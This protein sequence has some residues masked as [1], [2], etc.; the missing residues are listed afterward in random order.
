MIRTFSVI[1]AAL[2]LASLAGPADAQ[3]GPPPPRDGAGM[4]GEMGSPSPEME[5]RMAEHRAQMARDMHVILRLRPDQESAWQAFEAAMGP[6]PR[7]ARPPGMADGAPSTTPQ[8]LDRMDKMMGE[9]QARHARVE[10][11][12]RTFY[13]ALSPDQQQVFD[14]L[15]RLRGPHMGRPGG[16]N[17]RGA[18]WKHRRD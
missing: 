3:M 9:M 5:K 6:P 8:R 12:T 15:E 10:S 4:H 16:M 14:A 11:A 17:E 2:S 1:A 13:A 7:P 18:P